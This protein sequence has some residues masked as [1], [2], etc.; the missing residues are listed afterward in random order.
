MELTKAGL[1]GLLAAIAAIGVEW[2]N[3]RRHPDRPY[4]LLTRPS[5]AVVLMVAT[6][7][8][9]NESDV[10]FVYARY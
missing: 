1:L 5:V 10:G 4:Y 7:L 2:L 6:L 9:I 8:L 3:E